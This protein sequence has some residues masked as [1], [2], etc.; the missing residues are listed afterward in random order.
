[1]RCSSDGS[2]DACRRDHRVPLPVFH[3]LA[4]SLID[5]PVELAQPNQFGFE[6]TPE[7]TE[8]DRVSLAQDFGGGG[9]FNRIG[10][11]G[12]VS[13]AGFDRFDLLTRP[14]ERT[15]LAL[16]AVRMLGA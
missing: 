4:S 7:R 16:R 6:Q 10:P 13:E 12:V 15:T 2:S 11:P 5:Q 3:A 8:L 14:L 1:M 9:E